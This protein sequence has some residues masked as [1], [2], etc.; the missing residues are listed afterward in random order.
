M[1]SRPLSDKNGWFRALGSGEK[2]AVA[3]DSEAIERE[4]A[5]AL[6]CHLAE[7]ITQQQPVCAG[8]D[9]EKRRY[10]VLTS[11]CLRGS[12]IEAKVFRDLS[13]FKRLRAELLEL[14]P[15]TPSVV[16]PLEAVNQGQKHLLQPLPV[17]TLRR[18]STRQA[19][20]RDLASLTST[21]TNEW[22]VSKVPVL[23]EWLAQC[24]SVVH[25]NV[26]FLEDSTDD[27]VVKNIMQS[28]TAFFL[29]GATLSI[30]TAPNSTAVHARIQHF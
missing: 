22:F 26:S 18:Q 2:C 14:L 28:V 24:M 16:M 6:L 3:V 12:R 7:C 23:S 4:E 27:P 11:A 20:A 21:G 17:R 1:S 25:P 30:S 5:V 19:K 15:Q 13:D 8:F 29:R 10:V 9:I